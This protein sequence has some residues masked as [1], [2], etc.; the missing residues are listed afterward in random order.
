MQFERAELTVLGRPAD[1]DTDA[2][3][4]AAATSWVASSRC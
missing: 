2:T 1:A 4:A 3:A